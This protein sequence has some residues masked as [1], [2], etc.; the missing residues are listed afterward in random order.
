MA[1]IVPSEDA[2]GSGEVK[3]LRE[4]A[5][6]EGRG[7]GWRGAAGSAVEAAVAGVG[8]SCSNPAVAGTVAMA[9]AYADD[10]RIL[11]GR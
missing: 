1:P 11:R 10:R 7:H 4:Q 5:K 9:S 3:T 6:R 2:V 8:R